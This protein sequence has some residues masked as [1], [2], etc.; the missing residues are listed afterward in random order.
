[1]KR[2]P[3]GATGLQGAFRSRQDTLVV[4]GEL[5][6]HAMERV[7]APALERLAAGRL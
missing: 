1:M 4:P 5:M 7:L 2:R 3:L 6:T